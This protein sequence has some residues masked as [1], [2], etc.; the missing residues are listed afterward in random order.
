MALEKEKNTRSPARTMAV[1][2]ECLGGRGNRYWPGLLSPRNCHIYRVRV[3]EPLGRALESR[4]L[5]HC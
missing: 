1:E 4:S 3:V 2:L 5:Q